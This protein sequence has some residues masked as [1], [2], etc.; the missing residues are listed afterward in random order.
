M[1]RVVVVGAGGPAGINLC[2]ALHAAGHDVVGCDGNPYHLQFA[3]RYCS[4]THEIGTAEEAALLDAD[5][6]LAQP[7]AAVAWLSQ[8]PEVPSFVPSWETVEVCQSKPWAASIWYAQ[9]IRSLPPIE[10]GP[11]TPDYLQIAKNTLGMPFWLRATKGA[12][13]R[14]ATLVDDLRTAHHWIRYW[15]TRGADFEWVAEEYLPGRDFC[16]TSVWR[17]GQLVAAFTR[18]RLEWLYPHLAP[19]GRTG[20]PTVC[21]TTRDPLV[22]EKAMAAVLAIDPRPHGVFAVDLRE[23]R[24]HVPRPTEINCGRFPTTSPL[25]YELGPNLADIVAGG[26]LTVYGHDIYPAGMYLI[27]H[28]DCGTVIAS[29]AQLG[30]R[31]PLA[32]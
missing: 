28:I 22:S 30:L 4:E 18:E 6:V 27:R 9:G 29:E 7:E 10:F 20:T 8:H 12:G 26:D 21:R 1:N 15:A 16:W 2:K 24:A 31:R 11:E 3:H 32:A 5:L 23:D 14:G 17:D 13:A 19:S 25:Y